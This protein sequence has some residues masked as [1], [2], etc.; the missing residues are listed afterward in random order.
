MNNYFTE[1]FAEQ[2]DEIMDGDYFFNASM[3]LRNEKLIETVKERVEKNFKNHW[4]NRTLQGKHDP[5]Y[6]KYRSWTKD[7]DLIN[8]INKIAFDN[9]PFLDIASSEGMGLASFILK[10]NEANSMFGNRHRFLRHAVPA[11]K[12]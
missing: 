2:P 9:K 5:F 4:E 3:W 10:I 8:I 12:Y 1:I 7:T 6:T 11:P